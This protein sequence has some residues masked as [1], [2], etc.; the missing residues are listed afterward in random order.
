MFNFFCFCNISLPWQGDVAPIVSAR[1]SLSVPP[2]SAGFFYPP[3]LR[4]GGVCTAFFSNKPMQ[5]VGLQIELERKTKGA[6]AGHHEVVNALK[7][8]LCIG[9]K[10]RIKRRTVV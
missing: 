7:V 6:Q 1:C 3:V 9:G 10:L 4:L 5:P 2:R 8:G